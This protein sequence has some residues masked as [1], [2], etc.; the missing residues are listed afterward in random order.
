MSVVFS[1]M[2]DYAHEDDRNAA[3][4]MTSISDGPMD[5]INF[6]NTAEQA[7]RFIRKYTRR[8]QVNVY[9]KIRMEYV[10][11]RFFKR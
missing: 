4:F 5:T 10:Q 3:L 9:P 7:G 11:G 2:P 8:F 6:F 1:D